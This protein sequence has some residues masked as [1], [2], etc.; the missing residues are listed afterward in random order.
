MRTFDKQTTHLQHVEVGLYSITARLQAEDA[1]LRVYIAALK[2]ENARLERELRVFRDDFVRILERGRGETGF[3]VVNG[4]Y[5]ISYGNGIGFEQGNGSG[6]GDSR[7][8]ASRRL[9]WDDGDVGFTPY[10]P[11]D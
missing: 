1:A 3:L 11:Y 4:G 8:G 2:A 5:G 6:K 9:R 7:R 10:V